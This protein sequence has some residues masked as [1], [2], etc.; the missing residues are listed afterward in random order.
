VGGCALVL[1]AILFIATFSYLA[2]TF[3]YSGCYRPSGGGRASTT[4]RTRR[5]RTGGLVAL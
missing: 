5:G 4:D 1:A 2:A 3:D